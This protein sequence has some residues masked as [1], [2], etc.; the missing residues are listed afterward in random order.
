MSRRLRSINSPDSSLCVFVF[1]TCCNL[2]W[3]SDRHGAGAVAERSAVSK[4]RGKERERER[5]GAWAFE[6]SKLIPS[7][8]PPP[9]RT[10][11]LTLPN[12]SSS[13]D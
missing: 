2:S 4:E 1:H 12:G 9:T 5:G 3:S 6:I 11:F 13:G 10:H 7:N 8:I